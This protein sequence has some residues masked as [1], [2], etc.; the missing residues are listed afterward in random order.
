MRGPG[1]ST[2]PKYFSHPIIIVVE[3][4]Q[5]IHQGIYGVIIKMC[6]EL[7]FTHK[8]NSMRVVK[9]TWVGIKVRGIHHNLHGSVQNPSLR[10]R[11]FSAHKIILKYHW[12]ALGRDEV[13]ACLQG[14]R[15]FEFVLN[16]DLGRSL[17]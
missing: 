1:S 9:I 12:S 4:K 13:S 10:R 16:R 5:A 17:F 14:R 6:T 2:K 3:G 15:R 8:L 7:E 11:P